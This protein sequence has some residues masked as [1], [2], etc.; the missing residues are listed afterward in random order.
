M[1][2][3]RRR[4]TFTTVRL[5]ASCA[6]AAMAGSGYVIGAGLLYP[7]HD[8][9]VERV[10]AVL[11]ISTLGAM[12][13]LLTYLWPSFRIAV[14]SI[15]TFWIS[16]LLSVN[17][18]VGFWQDGLWFYGSVYPLIMVTDVLYL[19]M[20]GSILFGAVCTAAFKCR[21]PRVFPRGHCQSCGYDLRG[22]KHD[23]CPE[24]GVITNSE[25]T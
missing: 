7:Y 12:T 21:L 18:G 1:H 9:P 22:F 23:R 24:C 5:M 20:L 14:S 4:I 2:W 16:G 10:L 8:Y 17:L 3:R 13:V 15:V 6:I 25:V 19:P 11:L